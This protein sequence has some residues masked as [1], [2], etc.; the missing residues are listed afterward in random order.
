MPKIDP[1]KFI[2]GE[3]IFKPNA[4]NET[5][6]KEVMNFKNLHETSA[7][8][9]AQE[10][11]KADGVADGKISASVWN[12]YAKKHGGNTIKN[13]ISVNDAMNSI[14]NYDVKE[15][16]KKANARKAALENE[17]GSKQS[18]DMGL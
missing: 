8:Q 2:H 3:V 9:K 5:L 18:P 4:K 14:T 13:E 6:K 1:P 17:N 12:K 10:L 7:G 15:A 16:K 11:D